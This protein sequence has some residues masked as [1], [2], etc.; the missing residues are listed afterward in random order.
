M[1]R[2]LCIHPDHKS[3][4]STALIRNGFLTQGD[5]AANLMIAL[6]TVNNFCRGINVST[7]KFEEI[8]E[9]LG[10]DSR[11][12][13]RSKDSPRESAASSTESE[14]GIGKAN[15]PAFFAYDPFWVGREALIQSLSA[16]LTGT[17]RLLLITGIAGVGKTALG[18]RLSVE[19]QNSASIR[20][21][22]RKNF[23]NQEQPTDFASVAASFLE[24]SGQNVSPED[25][26]N[27]QMLARRLVLHLQANPT[28]IGVVHF[29]SI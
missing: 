18:E 29:Q 26:N 25:R 13:M 6:S 24:A 7:A 5:L 16:Q 17:C 28:L 11:E 22:L 2:S 20:H 3:A 12:V 27:S 19:L 4:V 14:L 21:L 10:L 1:P 23:D 15:Q 8:C 9:A